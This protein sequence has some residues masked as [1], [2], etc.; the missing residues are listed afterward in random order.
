M[1][2]LQDI[3][4]RQPDDPNFQ[5]NRLDVSDEYE[6]LFGKLMMI[7]N[8]RKGDILGDANFGVSLED[9]LFTFNIDEETLRTEVFSQIEAYIPEASKFKLKMEIKRFKGT[10]RD[11]ILLDF[12]VDGR[13]SFGVVVK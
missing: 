13:K 2:E 5:Y 8:T 9:R 11:L 7:L 12:T 3:Y 4:V 6:M 10:V 1:I